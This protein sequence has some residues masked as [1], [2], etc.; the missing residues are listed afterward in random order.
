MRTITSYVCKDG[1]G[2]ALRGPTWRVEA[3]IPGDVYNP[4]HVTKWQGQLLVIGSARTG[5]PQ[6]AYVFAMSTCT[7]TNVE[8]LEKF[9]G[10][11]QVGR[12][13]EI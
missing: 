3:K 13:A 7:W 2:W 5:G 9:S 6:K 11:V 4:S 8:L 12:C 10:H 1:D